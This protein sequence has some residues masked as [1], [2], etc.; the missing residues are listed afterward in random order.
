[1]GHGGPRS[2]PRSTA[3]GRRARAGPRRRIRPRCPAP[4]LARRRRRH[5]GRSRSVGTRRARRHGGRAPRRGDEDRDGHDRS[6]RSAR[7]E[8]AVAAL[9]ALGSADGLAA[10]V[11]ATHDKPAV[12]RRAVLALAPFEGPEVDTALAAALE[13]KDWQVRQAAED[14]LGIDAAPASNEI[15][16]SKRRRSERV[17]SSDPKRREERAKVNDSESRSD[18]GA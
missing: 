8:A 9:G 2:S 14:L 16:A 13:D 10:I 1:M 3:A 12:R 4:P 7:R 18:E 6:P 17:K 11:Q 5:S 15:G